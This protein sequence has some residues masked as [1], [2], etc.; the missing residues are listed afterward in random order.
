MFYDLE[1]IKFQIGMIIYNDRIYKGNNNWIIIQSI[2]LAHTDPIF[3][4]N[5][6]FWKYRI[7]INFIIRIICIQ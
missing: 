7:Y 2:Y 6:I 4:K 3:F 1:R 5:L